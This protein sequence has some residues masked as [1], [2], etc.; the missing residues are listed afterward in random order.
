MTFGVTD[1]AQHQIA[2]VAVLRM[3]PLASSID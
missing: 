3:M 2:E 1:K